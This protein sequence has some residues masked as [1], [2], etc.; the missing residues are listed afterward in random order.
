MHGHL[1]CQWSCIQ[2]VVGVLEAIKAKGEEKEKAVE[3]ALESLAFLEKQ[4]EG[5]KFFSG[6]EIGYLDLVA[7]WIS[8]WLGIMEEVGGMKLLEKERFP[9]LCEWSHNFIHIPLIKECVPARENLLNYF[10]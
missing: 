2:V 3:S 7:G 5:K 9:S 10:H 8:L 6:E 4:I 1:I